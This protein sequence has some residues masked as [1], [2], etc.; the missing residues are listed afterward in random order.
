ME[1]EHFAIAYSEKNPGEAA[2][3]IS[4]KIKLSFPTRINYIVVLFTPH[5]HPAHILKTI[6]L[7][8]KPQNILGI[9]TPCVIFEEKAIQKGVVACC[10]NKD[11]FRVKET[12]LKSGEQQTIESFLRLSFRRL[13]RENFCLL[14]FLAPSIK[15]SSYLNGVRLSLGQVFNFI[16]AGYI[17]KHAPYAYQIINDTISEG[18]TVVSMEGLQMRTLHIGGFVPL[19]KPFTITKTSTARGVISEINGQPA[20][21]I[22]KRYL[23]EK[24]ENFIKNRLFSLY[25]LGIRKNGSVKL[26]NV[27]DSLEDGSL[28]YLGKVKER[29][30]GHLMFLDSAFI[31]RELK[32]KLGALKKETGL[33][34]IINSLDRKNILGESFGNEIRL[35]K[36]TLGGSSKIIGLYSDYAFVSDPDKGY[37]DVDNGRMLITLWQ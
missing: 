10:I 22:Y 34:F 16:G 32:E 11:K 20:V 25:P 17:R 2:K 4:L 30:Q 28:L 31:L 18:L 9:Q 6:T 7:T 8:L 13:K 12:F 35:I 14:S 5:Y 27:I 37:V 33:I 24:F 29:D 1:T 15:P 19:G 36:Q 23:D 26:V 3:E 21:Q